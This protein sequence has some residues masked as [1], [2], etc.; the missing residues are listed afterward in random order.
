MSTE[1]SSLAYDPAAIE[2]KWR[3]VW[4]EAGLFRV[5]EDSAR[6]KFYN[7]VMFPYPSGKGLHMGHFR[8]YVIGDL[9]A[10]YQV[11]RG[12]NV[13][14]PMGWDAFGLP[15]ENAAIESGVH[16]RVEI[17]TNI[18]ESKHQLDLMGV[19][20][21]WD[22]EVTS[23][24]PEY[25]R[26][27]Q[28]LFLKFHEMGLAY[29]KRAPVN[30]CPKDNTVL[31][32]EQIVDGVCWRCHTPPIKKDLEQWFFK[33]TAYADRLLNDLERLE[34]WPERVRVMQA[35]WIGRSEGAEIDFPVPGGAAPIRVFT[36]RPDTLFGATFLV[37]APE[38]PLVN[39]VTT[40]EHR[41]EVDAYV[42]ATQRTT[43]IERL[44]TERERRGVFTGGHAI[45]PLTQEAVPIWVADYVLATYGTG[46]IMGVPAHDER[47][48]DFAQR[49]QIPIREVVSPTVEPSRGPLRSAYI[50]G[51][52][53]TPK[54]VADARGQGW[55]VN[56]GRFSG[57]TSAAGWEGIVA[58][59]EKEGKGKRAVTYRLRDWLISRQRYWGAPIPIVYCDRCGAVPVP[60]DQL[61]VEL[62]Y[63]VAFRPDGQSPLLYV[64]SF[65]KTTCPRCGGP[66]R[67]ETDTMD[68]FVDSSW[69]FLRFAGPH[70][71]LPFDRAKVDYW[72]PVDQYTGGI[73]HAILHLLY[74]RF[75]TKVLFDAGMLSADEPFQA[76]F[77]QGMVHVAGQVMS[78]SKGNGVPPDDVVR[79]YGADTGRVYEMFIGPPDQSV[80]WT[81]SGLD[82]V[83]RFLHRT[84]RLLI[85]EEDRTDPSA[86]RMSERDLLR[87]THQTIGKVTADIDAF[88]FNTGVAAMMELAN[89]MHDYLRGGGQRTTAWQASSETFI[90]LLYPFAPHFAEEAWARLGNEGLVAFAPW[91]AV[92]AE[93]AHAE[94]FELV[95]QVNG[96][97]R[98]HITV[99]TGVKEEV[100]RNL[101]LARPRVQQAMDGRQLR[102]CVFVPDR[103]I[104]LVA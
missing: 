80:E 8:N 86:A 56:S 68:T 64:E 90:R 29:K 77:T 58:Q 100:A 43:E 61:P 15:A 40:K 96:R 6:P 74:S 16:P 63:D 20:Y 94:T 92:D 71:N 42:A 26:W 25:Y 101:A 27:T 73:E 1:R 67:R 24:N 46:A 51:T 65:V 2:P 60:E 66:A 33:I 93:L 45:H 35:N 41:V 21:G 11:M 39:V 17:E 32:N 28:W 13:L 19:L 103:L 52:A 30:W 23:C 70:N 99:P 31:A 4:K 10:R 5:Q 69:Y 53:A 37:L 48:F 102:K 44:S 76:L 81:E 83:A 78:K 97:V 9:F 14:N 12:F 82:G 84:W 95:V 49:Y 47:D 18:A 57:L 72:M 91:P 36:T 85:G 50:A 59:L 34:R 89:T 55:M 104:N 22:R 75:F 88:H 62:P 87:K 79:N 3:R 7:L 38:H 98:D 54:V